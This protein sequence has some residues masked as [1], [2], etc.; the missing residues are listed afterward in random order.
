[1]K[2]FLEIFP[3]FQKKFLDIQKREMAFLY[4]D[5]DG[6]LAPIVPNPMK[7]QISKKVIQNLVKLSQLPSVL[8]GIVSGRELNFM[9]KHFESKKLFLVGSHGAEMAYKGMFI[10]RDE[11]LTTAKRIHQKVDKFSPAIKKTR[12]AIIEAKKFGVALHYRQCF[13]EGKKQIRRLSRTIV[14]YLPDAKVTI[15]RGKQVAEINPK[16]G[17]TKGR[18]IEDIRQRFP[19]K[20]RLEI[21]IGDDIS[22]ETAFNIL[23]STGQYTVRVRKRK[24]S[25]AKYYLHSQGEVELFLNNLANANDLFNNLS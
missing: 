1:M 17:W 18:A 21:Y 13:P 25:A 23:N 11:M 7:V 12:G 9:Q 20:D 19:D 22:D 16:F 10:S 14:S 2:Y 8:V 24:D 3:S 15:F 6:T 5:F 4:F